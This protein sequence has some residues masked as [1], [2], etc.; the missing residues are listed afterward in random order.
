[1]QTAENLS[2][3]IPEEEIANMYAVMG[4]TGRVGGAAAASLLKQGAKVRAVLRD[5][6]KVRAWSDKGCEIAQARTEDAVALSTAMQ[7]V[8]G[9]FVMLPGVFD[10][11]P[12]FPEARA[13]IESIRQSLERAQ[14]PKVVC[15][16]TIGA[17]ATQPNLL[18]Q[19]GLFE[20]ALRSLPI[21]VTFLRPTW[22][23]DNAVFDLAAARDGGRI[24]SYLQ[25]LD[26]Q[27][28]MVAAQDVGL[29][30]AQLLRETPAWTGHRVAEMTG[31]APV[32]PNQIAKAFSVAMNEEVAARAVPRE[33]WESLFRSQGMKNPTPRMQMLDGFNEGWIRFADGGRNAR[34]GTT[35]LEQVIDALV[36]RN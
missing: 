31:P 28:L 21:P 33:D 18:N 2:Q 23:M 15:L 24:D 8:E 35:S 25:P 4:I 17:D 16:S 1:M 7:G 32:T 13:A 34:R 9:V 36:S 20:Q 26:K 12:G 14:P 30:A 29:L 6:A 19:L 11:E 27:Y 5:V 22:F 10:P 3:R